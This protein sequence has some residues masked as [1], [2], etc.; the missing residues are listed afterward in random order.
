MVPP[1]MV[2]SVIEFWGGSVDMNT[3]W[4]TMLMWKWLVCASSSTPL[5]CHSSEETP[6]PLPSLF[7]SITIFKKPFLVQKKSIHFLANCAKQAK[8]VTRDVSK[9]HL[10]SHAINYF[11]AAIGNQLRVSRFCILENLHVLVDRIAQMS[12]GKRYAMECQR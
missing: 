3:T 7:S 4:W 1:K 6:P 10:S 5:L 12:F 9:D 11:V 2:R 8:V